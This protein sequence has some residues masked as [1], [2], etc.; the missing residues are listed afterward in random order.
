MEAQAT[1]AT[2]DLNH[3]QHHTYTPGLEP[4]AAKSSKKTLL[5]PH[6]PQHRSASN[7]ADLTAAHPDLSDEY[8]ATPLN[9]KERSMWSD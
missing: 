2:V 5:P 9:N 4:H 8:A 7:T 6:R 1:S 3:S